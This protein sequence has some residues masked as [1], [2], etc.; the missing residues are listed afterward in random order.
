MRGVGVG[1]GVNGVHAC[2]S[3]QTQL[4][5]NPPLGGDKDS[6]GGEIGRTSCGVGVAVLGVVL[7]LEWRQADRGPKN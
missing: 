2:G 4:L 6:Q 1:E 3:P 7:L 5:R